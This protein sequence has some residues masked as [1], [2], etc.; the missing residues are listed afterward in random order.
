[1]YREIGNI[2]SGYCEP[3]GLSVVRSYTGHGIGRV[4]HQSPRAIPHYAKNKTPGFMK[5]GHVFTIEPMINQGNWRD[6]TW[7]DDWTVTTLDG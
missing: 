3:L 4:F 6:L 7:R 2:I 5:T 1:M